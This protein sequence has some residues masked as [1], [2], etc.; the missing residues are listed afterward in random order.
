MTEIHERTEGRIRAFL[1]DDDDFD[2]YVAYHAMQPERELLSQ[3][4]IVMDQAGVVLELE[5]ELKLITAMH[6]ARKAAGAIDW[7]SLEGMKA[8]AGGGALERF[9]EEWDKQGEILTAEIGSFLD[10]TEVDAFL[11]AREQIKS[12]QLEGLQSAIEAVR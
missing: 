10:Q 9:K 4:A 1:E 11:A 2:T 6:D 3:I 5:K 7:N 12:A 8:I